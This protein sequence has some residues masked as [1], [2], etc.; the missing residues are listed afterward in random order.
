MR[1]RWDETAMEKILKPNKEEIRD[2]LK[3]R[4]DT[5]APLPDTERIRK[6]LKW[7]LVKHAEVKL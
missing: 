7:T 5:R 3:Q 6:Q 4:Q 2:W 1:K